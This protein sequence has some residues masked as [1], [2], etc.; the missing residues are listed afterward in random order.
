MCVSVRENAYGIVFRALWVY[1]SI[2]SHAD[3][4]VTTFC[5]LLTIGSCGMGLYQN[6]SNRCVIIAACDNHLEWIAM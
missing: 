1:T 4:N 3:T 5:R 6:C 2:F